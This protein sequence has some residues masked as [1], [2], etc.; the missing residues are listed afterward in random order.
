[1]PSLVATQARPSADRPI[2]IGVDAPHSFPQGLVV[3]RNHSKHTKQIVLTF[4][5]SM[6][7]VHLA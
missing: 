2:A 7:D 1:M 3:F 4:L 5:L 6:N